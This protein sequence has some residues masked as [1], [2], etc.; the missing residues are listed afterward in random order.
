MFLNKVLYVFG[1]W[2]VMQVVSDKEF[3]KQLKREV[4]LLEAKL[5]LSTY[6]TR[7]SSDAL[8]MEKDLYIQKVEIC[9][10]L[11]SCSSILL[12]FCLFIWR[13]NLDWSF[14]CK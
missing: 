4:S 6:S 5:H 3:I 12:G 7:A 8:L 14:L 11:P 10:K 1:V 13:I 9:E 2:L